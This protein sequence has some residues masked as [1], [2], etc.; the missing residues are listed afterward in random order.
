HY[1][2]KRV[3]MFPDVLYP[4]M[5][6]RMQTAIFSPDGKLWIS[7]GEDRKFFVLRPPANRKE[8]ILERII[9]L[10]EPEAGRGPLFIQSVYLPSIP[11]NLIVIESNFKGYA[12]VCWY[13]IERGK[14]I[15][16]GTGK[17]LPVFMYGIGCPTG[18][19]SR[20]EAMYHFITD[21]RCEARHGI[22]RFDNM[23]DPT[24]P[25]LCGTG[26]TFLS[27]GGALVTRYGQAY[28][29]PFNGQPGKLV[30]IPAPYFPA[31]YFE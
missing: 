16:L 21:Q 9:S 26:I 22:Y 24:I 15:R 13:Q 6:N 5:A 25:R 23:T 19:F 12:C 4:G 17:K 7:R 3:R 30:Y 8:W 27:D 2:G 20:L 10:P 18:I 29:G 28:P 1:K 11:E 14:I 31:S